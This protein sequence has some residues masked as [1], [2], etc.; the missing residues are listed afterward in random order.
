RGVWDISSV[1]GV[2]EVLPRPPP[3]ERKGPACDV[4]RGVR[5]AD[6]VREDGI[7]AHILV[8]NIEPPLGGPWRRRPDPTDIVRHRAC[9]RTHVRVEPA[10]IALRDEDPR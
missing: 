10:I 1:A 2:I 6:P 5:R 9:R 8:G 3:A 4:L 7:S